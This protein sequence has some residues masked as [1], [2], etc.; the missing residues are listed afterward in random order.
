M[1]SRTFIFMKHEILSRI[2]LMLLVLNVIWLVLI[3]NH[4]AHFIHNNWH[5]DDVPGK[6]QHCS[7]HSHDKQF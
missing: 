4:N 2:L 7:K 6:E 5:G 1:V 3:C